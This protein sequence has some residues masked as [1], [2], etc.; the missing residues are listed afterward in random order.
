[1]KN[2]V[3]KITVDD[4]GETKGRAE[5]CLIDPCN[6]QGSA[7]LCTN[8]FFGIGESAC[9]YEV[10]KGKITCKRCIEIIKEYKKIKL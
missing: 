10:K 2:S 5:W 6:L 9:I 4:D 1:M 8:E 3:V 7:T